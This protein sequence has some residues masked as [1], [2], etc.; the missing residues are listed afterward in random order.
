MKFETV[1][2]YFLSEFS[3]VCHPKILL[4]YQHD[5]TTSP[6]YLLCVLTV[7]FNLF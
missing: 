4:P 7:H 1:R 3:V 5:V 6:P 2:M